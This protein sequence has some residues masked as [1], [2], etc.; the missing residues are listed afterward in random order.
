M[1]RVGR[2]NNVLAN[3]NL[4]RETP[5]RSKPSTPLK[6]TE[7]EVLSNREKRERENI[8]AIG[9]LRDP[10]RAVAPNKSLQNV[11]PR[12]RKCLEPF[13]SDSLIAAF[14]ETV[15]ACPFTR[16]LILEARRALATEFRAEV[17]SDGYQS[18]IRRCCQDG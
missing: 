2:F 4:L 9:G 6:Q 10:R 5:Q 14:E 13:L 7:D 11:G 18:W 16:E 8:E 12:I 3:A 15:K 17:E 1:V